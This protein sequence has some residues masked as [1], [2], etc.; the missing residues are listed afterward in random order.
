[1]VD[2]LEKDKIDRIDSPGKRFLI[3]GQ[4]EKVNS[5]EP[6]QSS[7][8][9]LSQRKWAWAESKLGRGERVPCI[10]CR[11][12][13]N[14]NNALRVRRIHHSTSAEKQG[15]FVSKYQ[16]YRYRYPLTLAINVSSF[17][18]RYSSLL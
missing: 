9:Y 14:Q 4:N 18:E 7:R 5:V 13:C 12:G 16:V 10:H 1:M 2:Q 15:N 8:Q 17:C 11:H 6:R 3:Y